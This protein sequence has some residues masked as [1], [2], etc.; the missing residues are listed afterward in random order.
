MIDHNLLFKSK[1]IFNFF[2][3]INDN[4]V[5]I[6]SKTRQI[7]MT[8]SLIYFCVSQ[9]EMNKNCNFVFVCTNESNTKNTFRRSVTFI[10]LLCF[11][12]SININ[13]NTTKNTIYFN[14][15][16]SRIQFLSCHEIERHQYDRDTHYIFD[17]C[18]FYN[19]D[20]TKFH[21][22]SMIEKKTCV[23]ESGKFVF[24]STPFKHEFI[25][26]IDDL[27]KN[28]QKDVLAFE[29]SHENFTN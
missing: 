24:V 6:A 8:E 20:F 27:I 14:D 21:F 7:G 4:K 5:V 18:D 15:T 25:E 26:I 29:F 11:Q 16:D 12:H 28:P 22:K 1:N 10:E 13:H 17:E 9:C 19:V 3:A 2:R 23:N